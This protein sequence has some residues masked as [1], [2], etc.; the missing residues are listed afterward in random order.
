MFLSDNLVIS[1]QCNDGVRRPL[2]EVNVDQL[3]VD[4][5]GL[6]P[7]RNANTVLNR[8]SCARCGVEIYSVEY[9]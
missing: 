9:C 1:H 4:A 6:S 3:P 5:D 2:V 8:A 7:V